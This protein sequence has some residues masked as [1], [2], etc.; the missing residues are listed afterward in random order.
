MKHGSGMKDRDDKSNGIEILMT[1]L[2]VAPDV[3]PS[4][5]VGLTSDV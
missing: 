2:V 5:G 4:G 1:D 3:R